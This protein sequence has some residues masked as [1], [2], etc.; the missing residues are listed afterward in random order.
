[1]YSTFLN[2][3]DEIPSVTVILNFNFLSIMSIM[4]IA[5]L[6]TYGGHCLDFDFTILKFTVIFKYQFENKCSDLV[7]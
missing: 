4:F 3:I 6:G 5:I 7:M 1:M 2:R